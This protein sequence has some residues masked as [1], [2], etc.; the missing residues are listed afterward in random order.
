MHLHFKITSGKFKRTPVDTQNKY[1]IYET[2][3]GGKDV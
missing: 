2:L 1:R 3:T